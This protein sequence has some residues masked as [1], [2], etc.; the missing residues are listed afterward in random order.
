MTV[1]NILQKDNIELLEKLQN[2]NRILLEE[3]ERLTN[4]VG[5]MHDTIWHL[6][7]MQRSEL[8]FSSEQLG[9]DNST[10]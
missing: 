7:R 8:T 1:N 5:W 4:T 9:K 6:V 2:E 10:S 3:N